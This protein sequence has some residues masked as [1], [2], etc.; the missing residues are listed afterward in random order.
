MGDK[1]PKADDLEA[2]WTFVEPS[3]GQILGRDGTPAMGRVQK[4]L[5]ATMYMDVYTAIYNYCV[6]KSRSTG[7]FQSDAIQRQSNQSSILVGG[8]IY[9][10]L[11]NYLHDYIVN[12]EKSDDESFLKF[13]VRR[14]KRFTIGAIFLNHAFDYMNRYWVR[15]ERSDGK[16]NIF[17][18]NT[19]CLMTWKQ[20]MFDQY[21]KGLV[22]EILQQLTLQRDGKIVNQ[23]DITTAIKSFVA[24]G[25][26]PSDLKKLNLNIY[27]QN[28]ESAFL[29]S[30]R[31]YYINMSKKYLETHSVTDYI[32]E[33]HARIAEEESKMVLYLDDHTKKPLSNTLNE[34][35]ITNHA[36][37]L[38][39]EFILL[40]KSRDE[41]KISTLYKLMQRDFSLLPELTKSFEEHVKEVGQAEVSRL[42]QDH[43]ATQ[44]SENGKRPTALPPKDYI[45]TLIDVYVVFSNISE[46]CFKGDSLFTKALE[47]GSRYYINNNQFAVAPGSSKNATSKTPEML[48]KY[49]DQLLKRNKNGAESD[50]DMSVDDIM[51]IFKFLTDK[52]A[53]EYHYRKNF[54]KR[55]IHGTSTS[56]DD[57]EMVIQRLQSENSMEYTGKITKMFQDVRLS[58][59]LGQE[60]NS[61]VKSEP[62]YSKDK[63]PEFQPFVLAETMWPF[64]YQEIEFKLPEVLVPEHTKLVNLYVKKHNG[65]VLKWLWPLSRGEITADIGRQGRAPFHFTVTLFQMAILLFFNEHDTLTF[66]QIQEG[67]NLTTQHIVLSMAPF[68]KMKLLQQTPSGLENMGQLG[69]QYKLNKPYKLAK[70]KVNFAA[71]VKGD[72]GLSASGKSEMQ[73]SELM[74]KE[75]NKERQMFLEACIVRIMKAKRQLPHA[76]LVNECIAESHQ[77]FNAKVSLIKRAIDNLISKEYL[78]R[79]DEGESYQYL[80]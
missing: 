25:I 21:S 66:E 72:L 24:L 13:Y 14:W 61:V 67:T 56:E 33:A 58:K 49:S 41:E 52:D 1:L 68:I 46:D 5:S 12:L 50:N 4:V 39:K 59:Q 78:Q 22:D 47:N 16:R 43:K 38:K 73:D 28:F 37:E 54:A 55:L 40:L 69:T 35:L 77:R 79:S 63:Y 2:T 65:R 11:K 70:S 34:V 3:I 15:K 29:N 57:E 26:D 60:F 18:V 9:E 64:P 75:L 80:A 23:A 31:E 44:S 32:F 71:G 36:E 42:L 53:F 27:I 74:D 17:D 62:D 7:H 20:V 8:E 10:R 76:T 51:T 6:N 30:T 19:L 48:A 45:K